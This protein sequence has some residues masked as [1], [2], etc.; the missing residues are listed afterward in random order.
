MLKFLLQLQFLL[1]K[2]LIKIF[3]L[4][5]TKGNGSL[6]NAYTEVINKETFSGINNFINFYK[7]YTATTFTSFSGSFNKT[8]NSYI[9]DISEISFPNA[10]SA[11]FLYN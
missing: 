2:L 8:K 6:D 5:L 9:N 3:N 1:L 4:H 11:N 7:L 10:P